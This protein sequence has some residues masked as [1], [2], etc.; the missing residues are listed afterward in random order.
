MAKG[1]E[2]LQGDAVA[3][4]AYRAGVRG[5]KSNPRHQYFRLIV[6]LTR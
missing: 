5:F 6:S 4:G 3:S 2:S 1:V